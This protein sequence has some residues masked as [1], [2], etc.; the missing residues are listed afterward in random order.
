[1]VVICSMFLL[2][3]ISLS[4]ITTLKVSHYEFNLTVQYT[5]A[6]VMRRTDY[7]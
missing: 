7:F 6:K 5:L 3:F 1:M 4:T 2:T